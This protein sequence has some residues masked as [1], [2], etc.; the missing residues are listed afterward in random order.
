MMNFDNESILLFYLKS[1]N[2]AKAFSL[3]KNININSVNRDELFK[4]IMFHCTE[5]KNLKYFLENMQSCFNI[6]IS[7]NWHLMYESIKMPHNNS[8]FICHLLEENTEKINKIE[9][10]QNSIIQ[11]ILSC[12]NNMKKLEFLEG[13]FFNPSSELF[14]KIEVNS[15]D[16]SGL[17]NFQIYDSQNQITKEGFL[18]KKIENLFKNKN[19][20][21]QTF[22][23]SRNHSIEDSLLSLKNKFCNTDYQ[24]LKINFKLFLLLQ[25]NNLK[26]YTLNS[27][28]IFSQENL[29]KM[30]KSLFDCM[31]KN[32]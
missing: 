27:H 25:K 23:S 7:K 5:Y 18:Y 10:D 16:Q 32:I 4:T 11:S 30:D 17:T 28:D 29:K 12:K 9:C 24:I 8:K 20:L 1:G 14:T 3:A 26:I 6:Y 19:S 31:L 13:M 21:A 2:D 22:L 15:T